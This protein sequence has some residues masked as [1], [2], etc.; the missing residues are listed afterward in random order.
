MPESQE[1]NFIVSVVSKDKFNSFET[2]EDFI[3]WRKENNWEDDEDITT[4]WTYVGWI[5]HRQ[6]EVYNDFFVNNWFRQT[7]R[8]K[9]YPDDSSLIVSELSANDI[10]RLVKQSNNWAISEARLT[11]MLITGAYITKT[12]EFDV[13]LNVKGVECT[14]EEGKIY[15]VDNVTSKNRL[16]VSQVDI[17][18]GD[19]DIGLILN[20]KLMNILATIDW[21]TQTV[22]FCRLNEV[23]HEFKVNW[24]Q[25]MHSKLY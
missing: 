25:Q 1:Q 12:A 23:I 9:D 19:L 2:P 4:W 8:D 22:V 17:A 10:Y 7:L 3:A 24:D 14:D 20:N 5:E 16:F 11:P 13:Y 18:N 6:N 21:E 15:R